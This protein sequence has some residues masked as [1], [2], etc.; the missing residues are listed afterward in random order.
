MSDRIRFGEPIEPPIPVEKLPPRSLL[1]N[2]ANIR[3]DEPFQVYI[4][5]SVYEEVW[6]HVSGSPRIECGGVLIGHPFQT[7][8]G[9]IT[10]VIVAG[11][12]PQH[13]DNRSVGHFTVGPRE[14]AAAREVME[15]KY[16]GLIPVGWYH[17][18]PGHGIFLSGQDMTIV[19]SI[20]N[21]SW[22]IAMVIDPL[23]REEGVFVGAEGMQIG[24]QGGGALGTSW[25]G[26]RDVPDNVKA[27]ALY[28]WAR[29]RRDEGHPDLAIRAL[30]KLQS[31]VQTS[32]ELRHWREHGGYPNVAQMVADLS[33]L[34]RPFH[35]YKLY[36]DGKRAFEA[37]QW[38]DAIE[39]FETLIHSE[40]TYREADEH[41]A[42]A[43]RKLEREPP[44]PMPPEPMRKQSQLSSVWLASSVVLT[45]LFAVSFA[46][47]SVFFSHRVNSLIVTGWGI[48]LSLL[49]A[50]TAAYVVVSK[51]TVGADQPSSPRRATRSTY[52]IA[53]RIGAL[54]LMGLVVMIWVSYGLF[55]SSM[56]R[57]LPTATVSPVPSTLSPTILSP[58][59]DTPTLASP[60]TST[61]EPTVETPVLTPSLPVITTT[62]PL[63][64]TPAL[65]LTETLQPA[66]AITTPAS[67]V[68]M[69]VAS[70]AVTD[71]P[72]VTP[73]ITITQTTPTVDIANLTPT[74]AVTTTDLVTSTP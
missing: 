70:P 43:R 67:T 10:F 68:T 30:N 50:F 62:L 14:I 25:I 16:P 57:S 66:T 13:S 65:T 55:A 48:L 18:H 28:D 2:R 19:R 44:R 64:E 4:V 34:T 63:T 59:V 33:K 3:R 41:L 32:E 73:M 24:G 60:A 23:H 8:D 20:Y 40:S 42:L 35:I 22:H 29:E 74:V 12:I 52:L 56:S 36:E 9:S 21:S 7:L 17:S 49:A 26:L 11:A 58:V 38:R 69:P 53:E 72:T 54:V 1:V 61:F 31:L 71:T 45:I 46:L 6:G 51:E 27:I 37:G 47:G 39:C 15:R 5:Q